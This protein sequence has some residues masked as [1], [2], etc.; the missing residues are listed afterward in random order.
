MR[1]GDQGLRLRAFVLRCEVNAVLASGVLQH[2]AQGGGLAQLQSGHARKLAQADGV[3][4]L[5]LEFP[6]YQR[7]DVLLDE[8]L[9]GK[10]LALG[11]GTQTKICLTLLEMLSNLGRSEFLHQDAD[12]GVVRFKCS[13]DGW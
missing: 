9:E 12:G 5:R 11:T 8:R 1:H 3:A 6:G 10:F 2:T 13:Q 4:G 7:H